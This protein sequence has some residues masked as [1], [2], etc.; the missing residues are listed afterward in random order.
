MSSDGDSDTVDNVSQ[1]RTVTSRLQIWNYFIRE[2][3]MYKKTK[4]RVATC[5]SCVE[6]GKKSPEIRGEKSYLQRQIDLSRA[7]TPDM[8]SSKVF[9][10]VL[11]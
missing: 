4:Y 9:S 2:G 1:K 3:R 10:M 6:A 8:M 5:K 11:L 7:D